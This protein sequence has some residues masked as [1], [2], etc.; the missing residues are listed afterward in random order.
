MA[1]SSQG[2]GRSTNRQL[3]NKSSS[4]VAVGYHPGTVLTSF[5]RPVIG[6]KKEDLKN[7]LLGVDTAV[8]RMAEVMK[9][10]TEEEGFGGRCW[11]WKGKRVEW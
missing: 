2:R 3:H 5:T 8:E 10:A 9:R 1:A 4:A 7:G 11:D 6:D